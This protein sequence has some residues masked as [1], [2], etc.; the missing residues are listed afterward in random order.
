MTLGFF[1]GL[2]GITSLR[3]GSLGLTNAVVEYIEDYRTNSTVHGNAKRITA[4]YIRVNM[5][6]KAIIQEGIKHQ[7]PSHE[8]RKYFRFTTT[9]EAGSGWG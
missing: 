8:I 6:Q 9:M 7:K 5:E 3:N 2:V 1:L 4:P